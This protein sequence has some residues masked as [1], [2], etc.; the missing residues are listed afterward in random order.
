MKNATKYIIICVTA[1]LLIYDLFA[2]IYGGHGA[3]I[4]AILYHAAYKEP[5][6]AFIPLGFGILVGHLFLG[7]KQ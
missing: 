6:G 3:T 5:M 2:V 1:V 7:M 4:S